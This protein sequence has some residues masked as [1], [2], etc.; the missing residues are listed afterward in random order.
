MGA[1]SGSSGWSMAFEESFTIYQGHRKPDM[2]IELGCNINQRMI[3][4]IFKKASPGFY[5]Q[6]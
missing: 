3:N 2:T 4:D 6:C 5:K 1:N